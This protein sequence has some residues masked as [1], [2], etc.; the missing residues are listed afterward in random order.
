LEAGWIKLGPGAS[1]VDLLL[2]DSS[3]P[4][5][6]GFGLSGLDA[7]NG[8][9]DL[10]VNELQFGSGAGTVNPVNGS[11]AEYSTLTVNGRLTSYPMNNTDH[12]AMMRIGTLHLGRDARVDAP[13]PTWSDPLFFAPGALN[14]LVQEEMTIESDVSATNWD[15]SGVDVQTERNPHSIG[16]GSKRIDIEVHSVDWGAHWYCNYFGDEHPYDERLRYWRSLTVLTGTTA[17]LVDE[18]NY[19][20]GTPNSDHGGDGTIYPDE[21]MFVLGPVKVQEGAILDL[22]GL[23]L[24]T[25]T[26]SIIQGS[27]INGTIT[28]VVPLSYGTFDGDFDVDDDDRAIFEAAFSGDGV[29]TTNIL[30]DFDHDGDVDEL[31]RL[32]FLSFYTPFAVLCDVGGA[33]S[34]K[35]DE[36]SNSALRDSDDVVSV[37]AVLEVASGAIIVR[38]LSGGVHQLKLIDARG[39]AVSAWTAAVDEGETLRITDEGLESGVYLL[40]A[41]SP[42]G[43]QVM[44]VGLLM[45]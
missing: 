4:N 42:T 24:Y 44:R 10:E 23:N 1:E 36:V 18:Y 3:G 16:F 43:T 27:V 19:L 9:F 28:Q 11:G 22:N 8:G 41:I 15:C 32:K 33:G 30:C 17:R 7:N 37:S 31:D 45:Q 26:F 40:Q 25:P 34:V 39:R 12:F 5:S 14:L 20:N 6:C 21:A 2:L 35:T 38:G 13:E 29:P